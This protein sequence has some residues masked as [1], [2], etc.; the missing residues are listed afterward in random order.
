MSSKSMRL[1]IGTKNLSSWSLRPWLALRMAGLSFEEEVIRLDQPDTAARIAAH[2]AAGKVPI[3]RHGDQ[4]IWDSLAIIEYVSEMAPQAALWPA[5]LATRAWARCVSAEMHAGF[6]T[7][8][9][10][11][12]MAFAEQGVPHKPCA[13]L[14]RDIARIQQ[15]WLE[16]RAAHAAHG[17]FLFGPFTA[18]DA[19]YAPVVSRFRSYGVAMPPELHAYCEALWTLEPM[20]DWLAGS[21]AEVAARA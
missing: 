11:M 6:A 1:I 2:S 3:L 14:E 7:L 15:L 10:V 13:A 18:A 16:A 8:R 9:Q 17:P 12:P 21:Q 4:V 19:M 5:D 20:Q